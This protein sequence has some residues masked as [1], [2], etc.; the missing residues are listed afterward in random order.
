MCKDPESEDI[1]LTATHGPSGT[2]VP[3]IVM[4]SGMESSLALY[5]AKLSGTM[6]KMERSTLATKVRGVSWAT[7]TEV[8]EEVST[9]LEGCSE[10]DEIALLADVVT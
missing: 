4:L 2:N 7:F 10:T 3:G 8:L 9:F 5:A 6:G 1:L